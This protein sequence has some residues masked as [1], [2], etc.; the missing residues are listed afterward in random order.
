MTPK[1]EKRKGDKICR[2]RKQLRWI[3]IRRHQFQELQERA[4]KDALSGLLNRQTAESYISARLKEMTAEQTCAL[5]IIDL[6]HFKQV[7]DTLGHQAGDWAIRQSAKTLSGLFRARDIIGRL[8]G[9]E[10]IVFLSGQITE[11]LVRK[12]GALICQRLQI[13]LGSDPVLN[14]SASVGIHLASGASLDFNALSQSADHA[15]Y[16]AKGSGRR[17]FCLHM[18]R[19]YCWISRR[20]PTSPSMRSRS[21]S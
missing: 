12:K 18:D 10:F 2:K 16:K 3:P 21:M 17:R 9:D 15:L 19:G 11:K 5:F 6:D 8:G 1:T 7:N 14:L 4:S 20:K 13:A